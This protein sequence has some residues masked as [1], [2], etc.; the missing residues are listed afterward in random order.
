M[1]KEYKSG[2]VPLEKNLLCYLSGLLRVGSLA[3][4]LE[5]TLLNLTIFQVY[6]KRWTAQEVW[7]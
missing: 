5:L 7:L 4:D 6:I 1:I 2:P 3:V